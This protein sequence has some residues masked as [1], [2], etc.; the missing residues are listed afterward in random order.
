MRRILNQRPSPSMV[1][2]FIAL[3]VA[4]AG[5]GYAATQLPKNSVGSKQLKNNAVIT[6][7]VNKGAVNSDKVK[8]GSLL[9]KDFKSGQLP[10]GPRGPQGLQGAQGPQGLRG[11]AGPRGPSNLYSTYVPT[12]IAAAP[13]TSVGDVLANLTPPNGDYMWFGNA[14]V[15]NNTPAPI[16]VECQIAASGLVSPDGAADWTSVTVPAGGTGNIVL[17]GPSQVPPPPVGLNPGLMFGCDPPTPPPASGL[18]IYSN[19]DL[20]ALRVETWTG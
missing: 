11:D 4:M 18:V 7:K 19:I 2:A 9:S 15:Q 6:K 20:V 12:R 10:A 17:A 1:V 5:T 3:V 16:T 8:N 13:G 14:H